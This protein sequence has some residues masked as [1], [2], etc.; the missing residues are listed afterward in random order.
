MA[1]AGN[2]TARQIYDRL[3]S[4]FDQ[5]R[6]ALLHLTT[7][8]TTGLNVPPEDLVFALLRDPANGDTPEM[9]VNA[10]AAD[11][12]YR[13]TVPAGQTVDI[14]R[15]NFAA[16]N[17]SKDLPVGFFSLAAL[18]SGDGCLF[19][20]L[21]TDDSVLLDFLDGAELRRTVEFELLAGIDVNSDSVANTS[22]HG[23]RFTI[24]KA[25]ESMVL[26][27]GQAVEFVLR[28]DLTGL[29]LLRAMVQ[30]KRI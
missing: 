11:R 17:D 28:A 21:D 2:A 16:M 14:E 15:I 23:V 27:E 30:G 4:M 10:G 26:A 24:E 13:Y 9:N 19:R 7:L 5:G 18:G 8:G 12:S 25:G 20:V 6:E 3:G 1:Q 29:D 22:R